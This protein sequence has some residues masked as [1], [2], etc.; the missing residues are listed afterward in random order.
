MQKIGLLTCSNIPDLIPSDQKMIP[1]LRK[2]GFDADAVIWNDVKIDW[3]SFSA[4][5]FRNTWDYYELSDDF[6]LWLDEIER[7]GIP[8]FNPLPVIKKNLHKFYLK[9]FE[10][11]GINIIPSVFIPKGELHKMVAEIP[12]TWNRLIIKPA[13][14]AGSYLTVLFDYSE[15]GKI[16][17]DYQAISQN[18]D[19]IIQPFISQ[20]QEEGEISLVFF[21]KKYSHSVIKKPKHGDFRIQSQFGGTYQ[22]YFPSSSLLKSASDIVHLIPDELLYARVDGILVH[23]QFHLM[24]LE[25]IEPDLYFD[26][27][28]ESKQAFVDVLIQNLKK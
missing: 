23:D 28:M 15:M 18:N 14:S 19:L 16:L 26:Y 20:V 6:I 5:V 25:L 17:T 27:A 4:L 12:S 24:E 2:A 10:Q 21:D 8:T 3:P 1:M 13:I 11:N 22:P 7:M 9:D